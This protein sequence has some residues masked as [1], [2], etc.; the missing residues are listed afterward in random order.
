MRRRSGTSRGALR[1]SGSRALGRGVFDVF[2][3]RSVAIRG[4][5]VRASASRD[6]RRHLRHD[7]AQT[8]GVRLGDGRGRRRGRRRARGERASHQTVD[9]RSNA[10]LGA[11]RIRSRGARRYRRR[12]ERGVEHEFRRRAALHPRRPRDRLGT[13]DRIDQHT[14]AASGAVEGG[15]HAVEIGTCGRRMVEPDA[16]HVHARAA[17]ESLAVV[18]GALERLGDVGGAEPARHADDHDARERRRGRGCVIAGER[19]SD[20]A[21]EVARGG[22][23]AVLDGLGRAEE[24]GG[25]AGDDV[26]EEVRVGVAE[27]REG[28]V[29]GARGEEAHAAAGAGADEKDARARGR[30]GGR[31]HGR[32]I[33]THADAIRHRLGE[34]GHRAEGSDMRQTAM[35]RVRLVQELAIARRER[36]NHPASAVGLE[37]VSVRRHALGERLR[38]EAGLGRHR[39]RLCRARA[40]TGAH[41]D[42]SR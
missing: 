17:E 15:H 8:L 42:T 19:A 5:V 31:R 24:R 14:F 32:R 35:R 41:F 20:D 13:E 9:S 26:V 28:L 38:N 22:V 18:E 7:D 1:L 39:V 37:E 29:G 36:A 16:R 30:V 11:V 10:R 6:T 12:R 25:S 33:E 40:R 27:S 23:A 2:D 4:D 34:I 21:A 3:V